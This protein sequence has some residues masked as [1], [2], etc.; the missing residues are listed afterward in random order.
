MFSV[1]NRQIKTK[2]PTWCFRTYNKTL[3]YSGNGKRLSNNRSGIHSMHVLSS[4]A[5]TKTAYCKIDYIKTINYKNVFH[6]FFFFN[7]YSLFIKDRQLIL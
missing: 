3:N 5:C 6:N 1:K 2:I 4:A 7:F